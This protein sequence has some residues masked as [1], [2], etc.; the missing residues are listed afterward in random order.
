MGLETRLL[1]EHHELAMLLDWKDQADAVLIDA[2]CSGTGIWRRNPEARWRASPDRLARL[3]E[4][5]ARLLRLGATFVRP[6]GRMTYAVCSILD[7]EGA[8]IVANFL[9]KQRHWTP[10]GPPAG[11]AAETRGPG[12]RLTPDTTDTD[13]FFVATLVRAC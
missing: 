4:R 7:E 5:Q 13:G 6:G 11:L 10:A 9:T 2:P 1:N 8:D 3:V 12:V